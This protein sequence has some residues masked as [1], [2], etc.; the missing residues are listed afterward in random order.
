[1]DKRKLARYKAAWLRERNRNNAL[2]RSRLPNVRKRTLEREMLKRRFID[3]HS[4]EWQKF[5]ESRRTA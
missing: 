2:A 4:E 5:Y 3:L 1:M